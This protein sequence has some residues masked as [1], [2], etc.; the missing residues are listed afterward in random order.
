MNA[1]VSS[2]V[3][4]GLDRSTSAR[5]MLKRMGIQD[6]LNTKGVTEV[7]V[8]RPFEIWT[9]SS[10]GWQRYDAPQ[11]DLKSCLQLV[12]S[13]AVFHNAQDPI[14]ERSPLKSVVLPPMYLGG[15][16]IEI[17]CRGEMAVPPACEAGTVAFS[18]RIPSSSRFTLEDYQDTGRLSGFTDESFNNRVVYDH[19]KT[20]DAGLKAAVGLVQSTGQLLDE[21][22]NFTIP[23]N[24]RLLDFEYEL[25]E[26][27]A[28]GDMPS[29][30]KMA[31]K[32]KLNIV[33]VG[34]TGSG[35]T[36][37]TKAIVDL[38]SPSRRMI[39][40]ED[41][42]EL[43]LPKHP[44]RV[45]L[46]FGG[47]VTPKQ[48]VRSCM[49]LKPDHV[50]LSEIRGDEAWE[51]FSLLNTGHKGSVTTIH[52]N[53]CRSAF[54]RAASLVKQSEV[55]QKLDYEFVLREVMTTLDVVIFFEH[56]RMKSMFYD[57][58]RKFQLINGLP[59]V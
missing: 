4:G 8:N 1:A 45:H 34:G 20:T 6:H 12:N 58:V 59:V 50:F 9:E 32:H 35:K 21:S 28:R 27:K 38:Y 13:L 42:N 52:A 7:A 30:L 49:R 18:F 40:I 36:T 55:G 14:S 22:Y 57:P 51:Y 37:I 46:L 33:L 10:E 24:V 56:T 5:S 31:V 15:S 44:N 11:C 25:L 48:L 3:S 26:I 54:Y 16:E 29:F 23:D 17:A 47:T 19:E 43:S 41:V 53:D 39:T 2:S